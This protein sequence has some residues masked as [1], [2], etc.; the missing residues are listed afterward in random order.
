MFKLI[1]KL[2]D[3]KFVLIYGGNNRDTLAKA[4]LLNGNGYNK[5]YI[6]AIVFKKVY[7]IN[8]SN[9]FLYKLGH[10]LGFQSLQQR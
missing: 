4:F 7:V 8:M 1:S 5:I 2:K 9:I 10:V 3:A 6:Y